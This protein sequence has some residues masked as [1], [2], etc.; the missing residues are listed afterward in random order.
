M[1]APFRFTFRAA[2]PFAAPL[3]TLSHCWHFLLLQLQHRFPIVHAGSGFFL[4]HCRKVFH[5]YGFNKLYGSVSGVEDCRNSAM[6]SKE[7]R[8]LWLT[9]VLDFFV[10]GRLLTANF[11][12][13]I[14]GGCNWPDSIE[15]FVRIVVSAIYFSFPTISWCSMSLFECFFFCRCLTVKITFEWFSRWT[16]EHDFTSAAQTLTARR[17]LWY[18]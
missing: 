1:A 16:M 17:M 11:G 4:N 12:I 10:C 7:K 6:L 3:H 15:G 14:D 13:I 18:S 5:N 9:C 2:L 8:K